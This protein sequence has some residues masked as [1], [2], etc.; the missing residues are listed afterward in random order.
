M[1]NYARNAGAG[2]RPIAEWGLVELL[3]PDGEQAGFGIKRVEFGA[4]AVAVVGHERAAANEAAHG[5]AGV[6]GFA[7]D[8]QEEFAAYRHGAGMEQRDSLGRNISDSSAQRAVGIVFKERQ[9]RGGSADGDARVLALILLR[10]SA[11]EGALETLVRRG[12]ELHVR[13]IGVRR[14]GLDRGMSPVIERACLRES[15][16]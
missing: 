10:G 9:H 1:G 14:G 7:W 6:G 4:D 12:R 15:S 5:E 16:D 2:S 11:C 3:R 8:V 13:S